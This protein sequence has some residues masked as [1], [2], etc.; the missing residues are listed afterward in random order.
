[1]EE[2]E[3]VTDLINYFEYT[4][5]DEMVNLPNEIFKDLNC[6]FFKTNRHKAFG[7]SYYFLAC[8]L[9]RNIKYLK[10]NDPKKLYSM[11]LLESLGANQPKYN[12]IIRKGGVLDS[13][14]YTISTSDYPISCIYDDYGLVEFELA[15]SCNEELKEF[16]R[17]PSTMVLKYP[18][19][20]FY[21]VEGDK[22]YT[23][24]FFEYENT[25]ILDFSVFA[26]CLE[27][28]EDGYE[29]FFLYGFLKA[30]ERYIN[31]KVVY[32]EYLRVSLGF[33]NKKVKR[34]MSKLVSMGLVKMN[35]DRLLRYSIR[36]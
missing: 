23:G 30:F 17:F 28:Q 2:V 36:E 15:S 1:M 32:M 22:E 9:Y 16:I 34:L 24:T 25:H 11:S 29:L 13:L 18:K 26:K 10:V 3:Q 5:K 27:E 20:A 8:Y 12:Y 4:E 31:S 19:K 33:G 7:Y 6:P 14:D 21:R 35:H